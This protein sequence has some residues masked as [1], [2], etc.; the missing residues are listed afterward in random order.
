MLIAHPTSRNAETTQAAAGL[1]KRLLPTRW[2]AA[3]FL[4]IGP[5][6]RNITDDVGCIYRTVAFE[7]KVKTAVARQIDSQPR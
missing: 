5:L 2:H 1:L 4:G 7:E 6:N 3:S